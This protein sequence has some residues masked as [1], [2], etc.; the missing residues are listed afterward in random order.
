MA[1]KEQFRP[2]L[3]WLQQTNIVLYRDSTNSI[4]KPTGHIHTAI[5]HPPN[6]FFFNF[7]KLNSD[8]VSGKCEYPGQNMHARSPTWIFTFPTYDKVL[9][10]MLQRILVILSIH[11][12]RKRKWILSVL[13]D[14]LSMFT[15]Y[16]YQFKGPQ[17]CIILKHLRQIMP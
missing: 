1:W 4:K 6:L 12:I 3:S 11:P 9:F 2:L 13:Q 8:T 7:A 16:H 14:E 10:R 17:S 15:N 5:S